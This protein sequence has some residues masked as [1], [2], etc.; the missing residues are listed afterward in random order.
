MNR[1]LPLVLPALL[2]LSLF[3]RPSAAQP[4]QP[5][6]LSA[7]D[8]LEKSRQ[9]YAAFKT[10]KGTCSV[11]TDVVLA[12]GDGEPTQEVSSAVAS[13]EFERR[14]RLS[15]QGVDAGGQPFKAQWT[16]SETWLEMMSRRGEGTALLKE[17]KFKREII[18]DDGVLSPQVAL[19]ASMSGFTRGVGSDIP[20]ALMTTTGD[21]FTVF[22]TSNKETVEFLPAQQLGVVPCYIVQVTTPE[23]DIVRTFWIEQKSFLLRRLTREMGEQIYDDTPKIDGVKEP[24]MRVAYSL[25]QYVFATSEAK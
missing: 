15:V 2:A 3:A 17:A 23:S 24:V 14:K 21:Y 9:T 19:F 5:A 1:F 12:V 8:V 16:P 22:A 11:V 6:E 13:F 20:A 18:E 7:S 4:L 10:Y 25:S